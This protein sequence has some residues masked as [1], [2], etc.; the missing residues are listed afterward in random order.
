MSDTRAQV[1]VYG[2]QNGPLPYAQL[3]LGWLA[4]DLDGNFKLLTGTG[5][6][7]IDSQALGGTAFRLGDSGDAASTSAWVWTTTFIKNTPMI[8]YVRAK[9]ASNSGAQE[10]LRF[11]ISAGGSVGTVSIRA[12]QFRA[13]NA[14]QEFALPFTFVENPNDPFL[15]LNFWKFGAS[16][17]TLD[18]VTCFSAPMPASAAIQWTVPGGSYRGQ[19]VW[20]RASSAGGEQFSGYQAAPTTPV[21]LMVAP[22]AITFLAAPDDPPAPQALAIQLPCGVTGW[23]ARSDAGWLSVSDAGGKAQVSV[24]PSGLAPGSYSATLTFSAPEGAFAPVVVQAR[25]ELVARLNRV[26]LPAI[27][28]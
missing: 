14:Y 19:G 21:E 24:D 3:S 27:W 12:D 1:T 23:Q 13:A 16:D 17:V 11:G 4:D 20:A 2:L 22:M 6:R 15:I 10:A 8:A 7:E 5:S 25:L 9:I 18:A 28:R 26:M